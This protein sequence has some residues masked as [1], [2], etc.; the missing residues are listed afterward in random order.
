MVIPQPFF[1]GCMQVLL[2]IIQG[3]E[4]WTR[5]QAEVFLIDA[6]YLGDDPNED[7]PWTDSWI[8]IQVGKFRCKHRICILLWKG[9]TRWTLILF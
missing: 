1:F 4:G 5:M 3:Q 8:C 2:R 9:Y 7:I 6:S